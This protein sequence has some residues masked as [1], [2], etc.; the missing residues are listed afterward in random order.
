MFIHSL[1][2]ANSFSQFKK[3]RRQLSL[4]HYSFSAL[5]PING[6]RI[7]IIK[8]SAIHVDTNNMRFVLL[9]SADNRSAT[10]G[11]RQIVVR[12]PHSDVCITSTV[13]RISSEKT[14]KHVTVQSPTCA[15]TRKVFTCQQN[16]TTNKKFFRPGCIISFFIFTLLQVKSSHPMVMA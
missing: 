9:I 11:M 3:G 2:L 16:L 13:Q 15:I 4:S 8:P 5:M 6:I 14:F 10:E 7:L 1:A 12:A